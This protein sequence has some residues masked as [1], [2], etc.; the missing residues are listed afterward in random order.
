MDFDARVK[1]LDQDWSILCDEQI[2]RV[3][4]LEAALRELLRL[5]DLKTDA[6]AINTSGSWEAV[7]RQRDMRAEYEKTKP[8]A[9]DAA[10][11]ALTQSDASDKH[12]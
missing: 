6:E 12:G 5:K 4:V 11:R 10:R 8:L 3:K 9:W 2:K 1:E 7:H